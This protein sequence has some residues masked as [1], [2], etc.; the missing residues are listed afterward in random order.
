MKPGA[1]S[2]SSLLE[3]QGASP[4]AQV[5]PSTFSAAIDDL[6][7]PEEKAKLFTAIGYSD[8]SHNLALP[9]KV[10]APFD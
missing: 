8:S 3:G 5:T 2:A 10:M 9:R 7:T 6:M 4:S 1:S